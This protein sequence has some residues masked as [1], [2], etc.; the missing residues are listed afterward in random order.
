LNHATTALTVVLYV[1]IGVTI[2][3]WILPLFLFSFDDFKFLKKIV[4]DIDLP[5]PLFARL[6]A[7]VFLALIVNYM[8]GLQHLSQGKDITN[9]VWVGIVSNGLAC[10][11]LLISGLSGDWDKWGAWARGL[12]WGF[13]IILGAITVGLIVAGL[14]LKGASPGL[15]TEP[16]VTLNVGASDLDAR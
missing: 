11:I 15:R 6:L 13:T 3:G 8:Q 2:L 4:G 12:F 5:S 16:V 7:A 9:V 10:L 1:K 14:V